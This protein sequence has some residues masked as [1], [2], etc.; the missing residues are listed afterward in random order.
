VEAKIDELA[1]IRSSAGRIS[2]LLRS[3]DLSTPVSHLGRWK[4]RDLAAHLGGVHRWATQIINERSM[5][6]P[7]FTQSK[8]DGVD[9]CDWF[10]E[11]VEGLLAVF[12]DNPP[13]DGCPNFNPGSAKTIAWWSRRQ[14]HETTVHRWDAE[15]ALECT[16]AINADVAVDGIDEYLDVFVRTRGKQTLIAPLVL[17]ST[18]PSRTWTLAPSAKPGRLDISAGQTVGVPDELAGEPERLLLM[19]WGRLN[20]TEPGLV[21]T[22]DPKVAASLVGSA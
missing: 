13:D 16:D 22:G 17:A 9:L 6:V 20:Y 18:Q 19:L 8:L 10:D 2:E 14:M 3:S 1:M 12:R 7:S 15:R 21:V 5:D 4:L 11:G